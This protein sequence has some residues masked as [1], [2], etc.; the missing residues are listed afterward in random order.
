MHSELTSSRLPVFVL[1]QNVPDW[2]TS[3]VLGPFDI[4]YSGL[5]FENFY[6][7]STR[8]SPPAVRHSGL[9]TRPAAAEDEAQPVLEIWKLFGIL[10]IILIYILID[11]MLLARALHAWASV[12]SS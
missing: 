1:V 7:K 2:Q 6:G 9:K 5:G 8:L 4:W 11:G 10:T 12:T 3:P